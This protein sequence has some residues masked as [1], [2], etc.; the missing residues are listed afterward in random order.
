MME[1]NERER[2]LARVRCTSEAS[3]LAQARMLEVS[4]ERA[5]AVRDALDAG[6]PRKEIAEAAG[7]ARTA[8]YRIA[9]EA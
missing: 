4:Q 8:V 7:V 9:G 1:A 2:L 5:A 6:L 3:R